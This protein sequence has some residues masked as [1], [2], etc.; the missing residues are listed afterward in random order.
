MACGSWAQGPYE[1]A[2]LVPGKP[3]FIRSMRAR[4]RFPFCGGD[5]CF[6]AQT[7]GQPRSVGCWLFRGPAV[8]E[9]A[10]FGAQVFLKSQIFGNMQIQERVQGPER[11]QGQGC[12][13]L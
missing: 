11:A 2:L 7:S 3:Y 10:L 8:H 12:D 4:A 6:A 9:M 1:V 5:V 13:E